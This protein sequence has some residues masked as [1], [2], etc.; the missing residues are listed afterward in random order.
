MERARVPIPES[1]DELIPVVDT[2]QSECVPLFKL[3]EKY[4]PYSHFKH[5]T[6]GQIEIIHLV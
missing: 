4:Y 6:L 1:F 5:R 2:E 3:W